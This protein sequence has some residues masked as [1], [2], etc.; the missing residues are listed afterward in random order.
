MN[1]KVLERQVKKIIKKYE[2]EIQYIPDY[3]LAV[4][5]NHFSPT[6]INKPN[7][8]W[9]HD[10]IFRDQEWRR[11][12]KTPNPSMTA[13]N[14]AQD[15]VN[16]YVFENKNSRE[17]Q[18]FGI[19]KYKKNKFLYSD[20]VLEHYKKNLEIM[21]ACIDNGIR[22]LDEV[23]IKKEK[24]VSAEL[25][26][27]YFFPGIEIPT[28]GR[29]DL[30]AT[31]KYLIELKT[32]WFSKKLAKG[33]IPKQPDYRYLCQVAFYWKAT[34]LEPIL[35]YHTGMPSK[36]RSTKEI[37]NEFTIF[38]KDNCELMTPEAFDD[39]L[40]DCRRTLMARQKLL[41]LSSDP[42]EIAK[43]IQPDFDHFMWRDLNEEQMKEAKALWER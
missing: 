28:I 7:D 29:T 40:E 36:D 39:Y 32:K 2:E 27:E 33:Y 19:R 4:N 25:Y 1:A 8:V 9:F 43:Y 22:A 14:A 20:E 21:G 5:L 3:Y 31:S 24:K 37:K 6:Q 12:A 23:G 30:M 35:I 34:G 13:G 18:A 38:S 10:Y 16:E 11:S 41:Q 26:C 15:G 17:A 42:K